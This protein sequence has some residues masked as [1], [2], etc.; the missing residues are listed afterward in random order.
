MEATTTGKSFLASQI[1]LLRIPVQ[2]VW[3]FTVAGLLA[4]RQPAQGESRN[5]GFVSLPGP[6]LPIADRVTVELE[7]DPALARVFGR[8]AA[9]EEETG[10]IA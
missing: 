5:P 1:V 3:H 4:F 9:S 8:P 2:P 6:P 7:V 10:S